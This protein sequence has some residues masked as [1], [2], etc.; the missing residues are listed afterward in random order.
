M[1][2][3]M[4]QEVREAREAGIRALNSLRRAQKHLDSARGWGIYDILGG[5]MISSLIK[6][7]KLGDAQ[8]CIEEAQ[9][10]LDAFRREL[11]DVDLPWVQVSDFMSFAD[12]FF[13]NFLADFMVQH[14]I[15]EAR[16]QLEEACHRVE[17]ALRRLPA[18]M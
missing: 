15:N 7:S 9:A 13:D 11:A 14:R 12:C 16:R 2:K 10:D 18:E 1:S 17:D 5:G 3:N 4:S 8:R 6:H